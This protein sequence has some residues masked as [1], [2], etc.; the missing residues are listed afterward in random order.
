MKS[1]VLFRSGDWNGFWAL[2]ADNIATLRKTYSERVKVMESA[3]RA[4]LPDDARFAVPGGG[5]FFWV[6]M[7]GLD[8]D[9]MLPQAHRMGVSYLPSQA[10]SDTNGFSNA[11]RL[12]FALY[13]PSEL[14][15]AV[16]RLAGAITS[17]RA[18]G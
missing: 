11:L 10:F 17:Y 16:E 3:L 15:Q 12:S 8:T 5:Y 9:A 4:C 6:T 13:E 7:D 14:E 2:L 18:S 1:R